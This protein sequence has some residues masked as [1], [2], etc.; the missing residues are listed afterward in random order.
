M[1]VSL[2]EHSN[3]A[4]DVTPLAGSLE[5]VGQGI[6]E[7][8]A[9][10]DDAVGHSLD[11]TLPL[12]I[13]L[14]VAEDGIGNTSAVSGRV[15]VHGTDDNLELTVNTGLFFGIGSYEGEGA[16]TLAVQAHVLS[17]RLGEGDL[18]SLGHKV[19]HGKGITAG[20]A[21]GETLVG[22]VEEGEE[23]LLLDNVGNF[24]P[25]GLSRIDTCWVVCTG[26]EEDNGTLRSRLQTRVR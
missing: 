8:L 24:N 6:V 20:R 16:N 4:L 21:G 12:G 2:P 26:M 25:L 11:L 23:L 15:R 10:A 5:V 7:L 22:H 9:H 19:A 17:E 13:E 1:N 14:G 18:V 3:L